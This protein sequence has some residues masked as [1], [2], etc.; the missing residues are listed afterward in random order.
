MVFPREQMFERSDGNQL[1]N[2]NN[3]NVVIILRFRPPLAEI[4]VI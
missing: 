4:N 3:W 1:K 2:R